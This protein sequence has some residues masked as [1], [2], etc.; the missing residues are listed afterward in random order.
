MGRII[1]F[2]AR[3]LVAMI[4][5]TWII[6]TVVF[7]LAHA[8]PYNPTKTLLGQ[9]ATQAN[10]TQL[11]EEFGLVSCT[12]ERSASGKVHQL[13]SDIPEYQQ[14]FNYLRGLLHGDLGRSEEAGYVGTP[15][16]QILQSGVPNTLKLGAYALLLSLLIGLPAG[17]LAAVKQNSILDHASQTTMVTLYVIPTF[18]LVPVCQVMFGIELRWFPINGWGDSGWIGPFGIIPNPSVALGQ[19]FSTLQEMVLPVVIYAAGLAGFF[20]KSTRS[21][22]LEVLGQDYIR[23][24]RAKGLK[25]RIVILLHAGKNILVPLASIVGPTVAYLI[26]GAFIIET[27]FSI[28]GIAGLTATSVENSDYSAI[29]ATTILLV[30][31]VV[32]ANM[33]TDIFYSLV[34][35]RVSL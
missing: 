23:T 15:L 13:C 31:F 5:I 9:R 16:W 22:M 10:V 2:V 4:L 35:P 1:R 33:I 24:A 32:A 8:S 19:Q 25:N 14:Y 27:L 6:V 3:R 29:E 12:Q 17:I 28:P 18:V 11:S 20:A 26:V 7:F 34:D 21:F 30:V